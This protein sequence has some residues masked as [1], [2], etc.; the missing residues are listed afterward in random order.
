MPVYEIVELDLNELEKRESK[1]RAMSQGINVS[2]EEYVHEKDNLVIEPLTN[3]DFERIQ[4]KT[5]FVNQTNSM[6]KDDLKTK[7][8]RLPCHM[9]ETLNFC[10]NVCQFRKFCNHRK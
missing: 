8:I 1:K 5:T 3:K 9:N 6:S 2:Y 4:E 10:Q 7:K